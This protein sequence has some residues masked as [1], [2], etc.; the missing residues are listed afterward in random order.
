M[1]VTPDF[2]P[3]YQALADTPLE[4]WKD[5]F[6]SAI[7]TSFRDRRHGKMQEWLSWLSL[8][9]DIKT[10]HIAFDQDTACVGK[11]DELTQAQRQA[12]FNTLRLFHP[13]RKGPFSIFGID[14]DTEWRSDWKWSRIIPHIQSLQGRR[15]LDVGCGSGYHVLRMLGAGAQ[16]VVGID[17]TMLYV[18]QFLALK[19][20]IPEN[21]GFVLPLR[22]EDLPQYM[23]AF[24]TVFSMGVFY[25]CRSPIDHLF[26]LKGQI[27]PGGELV[28]ETLVIEGG[29]Q[30]VL[31]PG[32]RYAKMRNVWFIPSVESLTIWMQRCG[33]E[34]VRVVDITATTIEEQRP[35]EWMHF[36]SLADFLDPDDPTKT[37]EGYPAPLR[38]TFCASA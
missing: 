22:G 31:M 10:S 23:Q 36:E 17:P 26:E 9:P 19:H 14:I 6:R 30:D 37:I 2:M 21:N 20:F 5:S 7:D 12:L 27:R 18:M 28:L 35:T 34:G 1:S 15:V 16:L 11:P 29:A 24:D 13:W 4:P 25:H 33:F 8:L 32:Q 38:A 3:F